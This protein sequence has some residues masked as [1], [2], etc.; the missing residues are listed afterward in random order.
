MHVYDIALQVQE[1]LDSHPRNNK[2]RTPSEDDVNGDGTRV[3]E[4]RQEN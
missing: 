1:K 4:K 3:G 2:T